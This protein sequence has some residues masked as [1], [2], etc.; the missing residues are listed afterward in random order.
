MSNQKPINEDEEFELLRKDL[1]RI[2]KDIGVIKTIKIKDLKFF[3][4]LE[5]YQQTFPKGEDIKQV[6]ESTSAKLSAYLDKTKKQRFAEFPSIII[7][8]I[9]YLRNNGKEYKII[10]NTRF[11]VGCLEIQTKPGNATL[12]ILFNQQELIPW[13]PVMKIE[14]I[15][16]HVTEALT[17]LKSKEIPIEI[18]PNMIARIYQKQKSHQDKERK[19]NAHLVLI[20]SLHQEMVVELFRQQVMIHKNFN[21]QIEGVI[22]PEWAFLYNLDRYRMMLTKLPENKRFFFET[23]SQA[24]SERIGVT[25]NGLSANEDYKKFCYLRGTQ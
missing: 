6:I 1:L 11:R 20:K 23:G 8:Y 10:E 22:F 24:E 17:K 9:E 4:K 19:P 18:L 13:T 21:T 5:N 25:L 2:V 15:Q 16:S 12:R 3:E 7:H 14:E